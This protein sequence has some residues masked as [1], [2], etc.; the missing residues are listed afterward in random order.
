MLDRYKELRYPN[1][2]DPIEIG[3]DDWAKIEALF[4]FLI[5]KLPQEIQKIQTI[6]LYQ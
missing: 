4:C 1:P 6:E 5:D 3:D 2:S